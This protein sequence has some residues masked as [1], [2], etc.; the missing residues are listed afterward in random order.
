MRKK[1]NGTY[2]QE[3]GMDYCYTQCYYLDVAKKWRKVSGCQDL[4]LGLNWV[5]RGMCDQK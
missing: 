3:K 2:C 4:G 1:K 5:R